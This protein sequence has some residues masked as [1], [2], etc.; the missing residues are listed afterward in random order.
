MGRQRMVE[1]Q[2]DFSG[3]LNL[4]ADE[5]QL[6]NNELRQA[7]NAMLTVFGGI[8]KRP[9]VKRLLSAAL[10]SGTAIQ[11]GFTWFRAGGVEEACVVVNGKLYTSTNAYSGAMTFT[12]RTGSLSASVTPSFAAFRDG[13]GERLYIADGG[14]LNKYD[15]SNTLTV[16][17]AGTASVGRIWVYNQRL[18]GLSGDN[19]TLYWSALNNGD[20]LGVV[21]S[22]GGSA[23]IRTFGAQAIRMG[24]AL[25]GSNI[26][27]H[28]GGISVFT[29]W[30][31]DDINISAGTN[32]LSQDVGSIAWRGVVVLEDLALVPTERGIYRVTAG[33]VSP[34]SPKIDSVFA[35]LSESDFANIIGVH[36]RLR[37]AV[38]FYIPSAG[39]YVYHYRLDAWSGPFTG[40][41]RTPGVTSLWVGLDSSGMQC[42]I[43][44]DSS[45]YV[46]TCTPTGVFVDDQTSG[47][48]GGT[49]YTMTVECRR[50]FAGDLASTKSL[51]WIYLLADLKGSTTATVTW[52]T[53]TGADNYILPNSSPLWGSFTWGNFTWGGGGVQTYAVPGSQ[54]G[55]FVDVI[56]SDVAQAAVQLST[57]EIEA[58]NMGRR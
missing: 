32:G 11:N 13:T 14:L 26:L 44:G 35:A 53:D 10:E 6:A 41:Y 8:V 9:G 48:T 45:G 1:K 17:L 16:D 36:D 52:Q 3:G 12:H 43:A 2:P 22:G 25:G 54:T 28:S 20:T 50:F 47:G 57:L 40:I 58:F 37:R 39:V 49:A 23:N 24:F 42:V 7:E 27:V 31:Q 18:F 33:G 46:K 30:T 55:H 15:T 51:R 19:E 56:F 34:G 5:S 21:A 4:T 38:W 29:G